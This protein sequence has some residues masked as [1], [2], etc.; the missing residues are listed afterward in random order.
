[1]HSQIHNPSAYEAGIKR[2]I[3]MNARTTFNRTYPDA[4]EMFEEFVLPK[5]VDCS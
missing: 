2:N 1:M 5:P 3:V 4:Q